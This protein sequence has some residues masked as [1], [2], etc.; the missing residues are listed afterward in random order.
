MKSSKKYNLV[1]VAHPDDETIFF[2]GLLARAR[3]NSGLA[4]KVICMT[5]ANADG[6]GAKRKKQ[7]Q[8]ACRELGVESPEWWAYPDIY[9]KRLPVDEITTRLRELPLPN[10]IY[11]HGIIGEYG[12][13]HHQDVSFAVHRAFS[14]HTKLYSVAYN[15]YP[16]RKIILTEKEYGLKSK[17]LTDIYGSET[18]RFLNLLPST[19]AEGFQRLGQ[20][21]VSALYA[22]FAHKAPLKPKLLKQ[23]AWLVSFLKNNRERSRP[24]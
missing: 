8:R 21:E 24:F 9:E 5:D 6:E 19:F 13:P 11:T 16:E 14:G 20:E 2:G 4:W 1:C 12:H 17:I 7:F 18:T 22:F 3:S 23:Y 10:E 15:S